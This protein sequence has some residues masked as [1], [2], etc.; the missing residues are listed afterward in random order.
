MGKSS[1]T[2]RRA[3]RSAKRSKQNN[4]WTILTV[5]VLIAG[6]AVIFYARMS[7]R[8]DVGPFVADQ[9]KKPDDKVNVES[10]WHAALG[11]YDCNRWVGDGSGDG[12]WAWPGTSQEGIFRVG[13]R[14]YAGMHS[15]EDGI[16]HMEPST[17]DESGWNATVGKYFKF[18]GWK[19]SED[20]Y[21]FLGSNK[22]NGDK[23]GDQPGH[24]VWGVGKLTGDPAQKVVIEE[25]TGNPAHYK[26]YNDDVVVLAYLPEGQSLAD[27]PN[28]PSVI[29]LP[30]AGS[31]A[32][33][34][35]Q[36][37]SASTVPGTTPGSTTAGST[38]AGS[39]VAGSSTPASSTP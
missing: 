29:N 30:D 10:H 20:G 12:V 22:H 2:K 28:P 32:R 13:T 38:T 14:V 36:V 9:N 8:D 21:E 1:R 39:T 33:E 11:V 18:G 35:G 24:F 3:V 34:N 15:H 19:V 25:K 4:W 6:V 27:L 7:E 23:C 17:A 5:L 16:I 37:P 26:L 31:S